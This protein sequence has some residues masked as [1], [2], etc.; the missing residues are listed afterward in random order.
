[1]CST[2]FQSAF[3]M[4]HL[5]AE[6]S[7]E[8]A[9]RFIRSRWSVAPTVGMVLGSGL[10]G[11][12]SHVAPGTIIPY[13]EIP[14]F[15]KST[16]AGHRGQL[17]CGHLAEKPIVAMQG[18]FHMYEGK[19]FSDVSFPIH[20]MC[21]LGIRLLIVSNAAGG[22]NPTYSAGDVML[23]NSHLDLT[24]RDRIL[25]P[26]SGS[27]GTD[28]KDP[29]SVAALR[30]ASKSQPYDQRLIPIAL[31]T[32]RR[33]DFAAHVGTYIALTGPTYETRA[34]YRMLRRLG[35]DAVG[36]STVPEVVTANR[37]GVPVLGLSTIT[38]VA[39]PD[40]LGITTHQDVVAT[41]RSAESKLHAIV[42]TVLN[43]LA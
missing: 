12:A 4:N 41:A 24:F 32:A 11:V 23:I 43:E 16:V 38:N 19:S 18:R 28:R 5:A 22:L 10:G 37:Y 39:N 26:S 33:Q 1:M 34:E 36:M 40:S 20:V 31:Q 29:N 8:S 42:L 21:R 27:H 15:S 14:H 3:L 35:G 9:I 30:P 2:D 13:S 7:I 25:M 17:V 6:Q